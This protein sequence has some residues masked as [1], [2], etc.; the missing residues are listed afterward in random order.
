[1]LETSLGAVPRLRTFS[2][3]TESQDGYVQQPDPLADWPQSGRIELKDLH[4]GYDPSKPILRGISLA[5][6]N[7]EKVGICGRTGSGKLTILSAIARLLEPSS[8]AILIDGLSIQDFS[9]D[10]VRNR[11]LTLPQEPILLDGSLRFNVDPA[12]YFSDDL[13][14]GA[15]QKCLL[16]PDPLLA[17]AELVDLSG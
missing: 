1:M 7:A 17:S 10:A 4:A 9:P 3:E 14:V 11:V 12:G 13:I 5:I 16:L 6:G 8:G 15:L 2:A